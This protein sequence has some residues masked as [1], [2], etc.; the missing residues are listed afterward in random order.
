MPELLLDHLPLVLLGALLGL[1][2]V[3]FPQAMVSRPLV[4]ATLGGTL[5]GGPVAGLTLGCILELFA[6]ET[7][8][9]GASRYPEW[10]S[11]AAVA[12]G[13]YASEDPSRAGAIALAV[14]LA[15]VVAQVGGQSMIWLRQ[16]N[17]RWARARSAQLEA[18]DAG[19]VIGL[20]VMG[21][22][23]DLVRGALVASVGLLAGRLLLPPMLD[24]WRDSEL[25][26]R[27]GTVAVA[28][29]VAAAA[30]WKLF[31]VVR[32]GRLLFSAGLAGGLLLF[33]VLR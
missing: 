2:V 29:A 1:D 3:S 6:L 33:L 25:V 17:G 14:L 13:L 10:G 30:A 21:L 28:V 8:P 9:F 11:A 24:A 26:A 31:H 18:G 27:G 5:V 20:Q 15:L 7:L 22:V 4:A 23:A 19:A 32:G 12:G 16:L